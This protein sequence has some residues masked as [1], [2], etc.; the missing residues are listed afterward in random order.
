M[1]VVSKSH[2]APFSYTCS[3][4]QV[5]EC[6]EFEE[7]AGF[8]SKF[9]SALWTRCELSVNALWLLCEWSVSPLWMIC[10]CS[11]NALW[12][13]CDRSIVRFRGSD[14]LSVNRAWRVVRDESLGIRTIGAWASKKSG[15]SCMLFENI[16]SVS[17]QRI[18]KSNFFFSK[19][20]QFLQFGHEGLA[21]DKCVQINKFTIEFCFSFFPVFS[22]VCQGYVSALWVLCESSVPALWRVCDWVAFL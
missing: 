16:Q 18:N 9:V 12:R 5:S 20:R 15:R 13:V 11:V 2:E 17:Y 8:C 4:S 21:Y 22:R 14:S 3:N 1:V 7:S 10:E 19:I 6:V